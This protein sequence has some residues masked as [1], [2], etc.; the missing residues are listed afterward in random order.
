MSFRSCRT[1]WQHAVDAPVSCHATGLAVHVRRR[2]C[3]RWQRVLTAVSSSRRALGNCG[4][5]QLKSCVLLRWGELARQKSRRLLLIQLNVF[6]QQ[7]G[8]LTTPRGGLVPPS[9]CVVWSLR[10]GHTS[11]G[12]AGC[13]GHTACCARH[14]DKWFRMSVVSCWSSKA[15]CG[16]AAQRVC[17]GSASCFKFS[18]VQ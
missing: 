17:A 6:E 1:E 14:R 8:C 13:C 18:S 3:G 5:L 2:L 12:E 15:V 7:L 11:L 9:Y 16:V 10:D 4:G